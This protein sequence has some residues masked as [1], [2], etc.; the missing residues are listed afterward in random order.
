MNFR[1]AAA[2]VRDARSLADAVRE[3]LASPRTR[4]EE[5]ARAA[6]KVFYEPGRATERGVQL[7]YELIELP[8]IP[9]AAVAR[10]AGACAA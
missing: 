9:S 7:I 1:S 8:P 10:S 6:S 4:A 2:V 5:R 3:A